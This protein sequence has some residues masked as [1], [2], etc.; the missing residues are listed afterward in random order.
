MALKIR[1]CTRR[2]R[3]KRI[4]ACT[5]APKPA[6]DP[7]LLMG[8]LRVTALSF[9]AP[10]PNVFLSTIHLKANSKHMP[11]R[12][13]TRQHSMLG[14]A[15]MKW[16]PR[17]AGCTLLCGPKCSV[18]RLLGATVSRQQ[19]AALPC[20]DPSTASAGSL[21]QMCPDN[22][23]LHSFVWDAA[24]AVRK[25]TKKLAACRSQ[26]HSAPKAR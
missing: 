3:I 17:T 26:P 19:L 24:S 8:A 12:H 13:E 25:P 2:V 14:A 1:V 10:W 6:S 11:V 20:M 16:F 5:V 15:S 22:C 18:G 7:T 21:V 9:Y 4:K 23:W